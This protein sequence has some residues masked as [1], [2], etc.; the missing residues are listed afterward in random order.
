MNGFVSVSCLVWFGSHGVVWRHVLLSWSISPPPVPAQPP[1]GPDSTSHRYLHALTSRAEHDH[2]VSKCFGL[3]CDFA[4]VQSGPAEVPCA[5]LLVFRSWLRAVLYAAVCPAQS[6]LTN[7]HL[8]LFLRI[9]GL[10]ATAPAHPSSR[11]LPVR[12][13]RARWALSCAVLATEAPRSPGM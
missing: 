1:A 4:G 11:P 9:P 8:T 13:P 10:A 12:P 5:F 7:A 6:F 2:A 3:A